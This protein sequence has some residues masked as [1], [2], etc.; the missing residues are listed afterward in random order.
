MDLKPNLVNRCLYGD[1]KDSPLGAPSLHPTEAT[2]T[3][4]STQNRLLHSIESSRKK[5]LSLVSLRRHE[6][7]TNLSIRT[8]NQGSEALSQKMKLDLSNRLL[9]LQ[10]KQN[11]AANTSFGSSKLSSF[12]PLSGTN[13][14]DL[15]LQSVT[16]TTSS[17]FTMKPG[18]EKRSVNCS[19]T[20]KQ[21]QGHRTF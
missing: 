9:G 1:S 13:K 2:G 16:F 4:F 19:F 10:A 8:S 14:K 6:L 12:S 3:A 18:G 7:L 21:W 15:K 5:P 17:T 11:N 20:L